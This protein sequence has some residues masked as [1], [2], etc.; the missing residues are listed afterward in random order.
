MPEEMP[1]DFAFSVRF[2][3][4]G[5]NEISTFEHMITKDLVSK[6]AAT[7]NLTLAENEM[8]DIYA[9]MREI[10]VM[11]D[12]QLEWSEKNCEVTADAVKLKELR[13][14]IRELVVTKLEYL[15][16]PEAVGGYQ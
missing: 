14:Y 11:G 7:A 5:K 6:G 1:E 10:N 16:L 15:E 8:A 4:T 12:M 3:I 13:S 9:R 2:G